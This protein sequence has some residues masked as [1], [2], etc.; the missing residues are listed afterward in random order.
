MKKQYVSPKAEKLAFQYDTIVVSSGMNHGD[1]GH[2]VGGGKGC[3][4]VPGH[5]GP[6]NNPKTAH[7]V[8]G[9]CN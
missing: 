1:R 2:G 6:G 5:L 9:G 3:N 8:F 7:P 4:K